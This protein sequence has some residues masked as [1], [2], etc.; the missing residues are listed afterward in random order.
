MLIAIDVPPSRS[1]CRHAACSASAA[2]SDATEGPNL[3]P[4]PDA[5]VHA[6]FASCGETQ[7]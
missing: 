6:T 4:L 5:E 3:S 7:E 1:A 2:L